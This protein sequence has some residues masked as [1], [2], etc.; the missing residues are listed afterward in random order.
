M[1][2]DEKADIMKH[3]ENFADRPSDDI[4]W[5]AFVMKTENGRIALATKHAPKSTRLCG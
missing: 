2:K 4:V 5:I 1:T 3:I